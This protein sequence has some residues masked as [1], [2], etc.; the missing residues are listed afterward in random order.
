M[1]EAIKKFFGDNGEQALT[2]D[3]LEKA[4]KDD[5]KVKY[6]NLEDGNYVS[7][8]KFN[9]ETEKLNSQVTELQNQISQ[10]D[11]DMNGLKEKI[12]AAEADKQKLTEVTDQ[13]AQLQS[14]YEQQK[15]DYDNKLAEQSYEFA[16]REATGKL[17]FSSESAKRAFTE[18]AL[19]KKLQMDNGRLLG[20]DDFVSGYKEKDPGAFKAEDKGDAGQ[21]QN[22]GDG[23]NQPSIVQPAAHGKQTNTQGFNFHFAGVRPEPTND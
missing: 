8:Q 5:G 19:A 7:K 9:H 3:Q 17:A 23:D 4:I 16:V 15:T 21:Q 20:F 11:A 13:L 1:L 22:N 6:V 18:D 10:R 14:T 12:T 2:Y